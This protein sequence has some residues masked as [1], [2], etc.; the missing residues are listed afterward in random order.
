MKH[1]RKG[2]IVFLNKDSCEYGYGIEYFG[3]PLKITG[4][5]NKYMPARE[6]FASGKPDG[7]HPGYDDG[8]GKNMADRAWLYDVQN[9]ITKQ[10]LQFSLY[11]FELQV[12]N[13][14]ED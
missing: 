8:G 7:Y 5:A 1:Y 9:N 4:V 14:K 10:D 13:P 12:D 6:F 3:I 11:D 2:N